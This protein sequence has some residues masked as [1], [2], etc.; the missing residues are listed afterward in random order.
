V[1]K[2][3]T[4]PSGQSNLFQ[5]TESTATVRLRNTKPAGMASFNNLYTYKNKMKR[6]S[7]EDILKRTALLQHKI[8]ERHD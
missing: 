3:R 2:N 6:K 8:R 4:S 7:N 5:N 1:L